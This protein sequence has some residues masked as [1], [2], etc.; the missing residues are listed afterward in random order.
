MPFLGQPGSTRYANKLQTNALY[1]GTGAP[2]D[3]AGQDVRGRAVL[4][5]RS[6]QLTGQQRAQAAAAAGAEMLI[7]VNDSPA[8]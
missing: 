2:E 1:L 3:Y 7:V 5:T 4:V 6:D 8:K